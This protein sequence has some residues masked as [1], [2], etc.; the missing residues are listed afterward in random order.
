MRVFEATP[1]ATPITTARRIRLARQRR[2]LSQRQ[3]A[4]LLCVSSGVVCL[5]ETR[6]ANARPYLDGLAEALGVD[7]AW[8]EGEA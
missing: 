3:L 4:E 1:A 6:K 8:L 2:R 5:W 7:V